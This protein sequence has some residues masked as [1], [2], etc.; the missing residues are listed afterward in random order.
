L[1]ADEL[2]AD[3]LSAGE[4]LLYQFKKLPLVNNLHIGENPPNLVTLF[5]GI[6][7][8][9]TL[10]VLGEAVHEFRLNGSP[11][12]GRDEEA[13]RCLSY[14]KSQILVYNYL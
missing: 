9:K 11:W 7:T 1:S 5:S 8:E 13:T 6:D 2:L 3:E 12:I 10:V 14:Q 4:L